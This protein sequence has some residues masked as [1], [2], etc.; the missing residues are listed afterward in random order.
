MPNHPWPRFSERPI[1]VPYRHRGRHTLG[2]RQLLVGPW[3]KALGICFRWLYSSQLAHG[4][5]HNKPPGV[6]D[7]ACALLSDNCRKL[8]IRTGKAETIY[9]VQYINHRA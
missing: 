8:E 9:C 1:T 7:S 5:K 4:S 6:C 2:I 3:E